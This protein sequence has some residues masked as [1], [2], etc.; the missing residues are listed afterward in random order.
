[1]RIDCTSSL[2]RKQAV[3]GPADTTEIWHDV[4]E[5][6]LQVA[7]ASSVVE[8]SA[9]QVLR[10][11]RLLACKPVSGHSGIRAASLRRQR[12][13]AAAFS[14]QTHPAAHS[15]PKRLDCQHFEQ[16][17]G[18]TV[19]RVDKPPIL[20]EARAFAA[21]LGV[22]EF[23]FHVGTPHGWRCRARLAVRGRRGDPVIGLFRAGTHDAIDVPHC[24]WPHV[25]TMQNT[26]VQS[27]GAFQCTVC[28]ALC[29]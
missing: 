9:M 28:I 15:P 20:E 25:Q 8:P 10:W 4:D 16:C 6:S 18:C 7:A 11:P 14:V 26:C 5:A 3:V 27:V 13:T 17:S 22:Q 24:R 12:L 23:P 2:Q 1:M 21:Q 29:L 19:D